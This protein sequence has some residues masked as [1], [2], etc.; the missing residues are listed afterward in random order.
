MAHFTMVGNRSTEQWE[1]NLFNYLL[2]DD[3]STVISTTD[4]TESAD[5]IIFN[6]ITSD[7]DPCEHSGIMKDKEKTAYGCTDLVQMDYKTRF[8]REA[9]FSQ[10]DVRVLLTEDSHLQTLVLM[11]WLK[12]PRVTEFLV[13]FFVDHED[14][15]K[16]KLHNKVIK[17]LQEQ[18][19]PNVIMLPAFKN[20]NGI[21]RSLYVFDETLLPSLIELANTLK[22][23]L[24]ET[25]VE[26]T[27]SYT[28]IP[29]IRPIN[30]STADI[31]REIQQ[32]QNKTP[33][34]PIVPMKLI[35]PITLS[36]FAFFVDLDSPKVRDVLFPEHKQRANTIYQYF[37]NKLPMK[38][39]FSL[40]LYKYTCLFR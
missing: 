30:A 6:L 18:R 22:K 19:L 33:E 10:R 7:T 32:V 40:K 29:Y 38:S 14:S 2:K 11:A 28:L 25:P 13:I 16:R 4:T 15:F 1:R 23:V 20:G 26:S 8:L 36:H 37:V 31:S 39:T 5:A 35:P 27:N 21:F 12:K 17:L 24:N 3:S 9:L 34:K